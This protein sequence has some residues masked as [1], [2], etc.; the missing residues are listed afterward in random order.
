MT[1]LLKH[2]TLDFG[3]SHDLRVRGI[4]SRIGLYTDSTELAWDSFS[5][6][7]S[8]LPPLALSPSK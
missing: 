8:A 3:S 6:S 4:E 7:L 2:L 5:S 1:H